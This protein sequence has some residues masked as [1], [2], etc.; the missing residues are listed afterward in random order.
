MANS[1]FNGKKLADLYAGSLTF[2][3]MITATPLVFGLTAPLAAE[4]AALHSSFADLY[5]QALAPD[6]RTKPVII[7][8]NN[9]AAV[10]RARAA[11]LAKL[12]EGTATVTDQQ[13]ASLGLSVRKVPAPRPAPGQPGNFGVRLA[14]DGS[15]EV[16]WKC[17]SHGGGT[18][19]QCFRRDTPD[20]DFVFVAATGQKRLID[21]TI[22][23]GT[24]SV[25]YQI[26][27]VRSTAGGP[28]AQF[29]V[30]FGSPAAGPIATVLSAGKAKPA[31]AKLA[32]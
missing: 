10:L 14:G 27:A 7:G 25:T 30:T 16:T 21:A 26:Q 15:L 8:R 20:G 19:Y 5:L 2:S 23:T 17:K 22:P 1:F 6:T 3:E 9:A 13:R 29:N 32:A 24:T 4:Y 31:S 11:E 12:I 28:W 18:M